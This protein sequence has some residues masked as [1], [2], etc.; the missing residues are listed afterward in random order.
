MVGQ[1]PGII[2][3]ELTVGIPY[4]RPSTGALRTGNNKENLK[5]LL[6]KFS[7]WVTNC[8]HKE[9]LKNQSS[10]DAPFPLVDR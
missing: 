8:K 10:I 7:P 2:K 6:E 4:D 5:Q 9:F 3:E 1:G